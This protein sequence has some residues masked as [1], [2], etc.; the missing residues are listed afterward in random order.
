MTSAVD[1]LFRNPTTGRLVI[2][3]PPNA[4]LW[5]FL[6]ASV[7]RRLADP[8]GLPGTLLDGAAAVGLV[9]WAGDEMARGDSRFRRLLGAVVL[10]AFVL[11]LIRR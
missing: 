4:P 6:A 7:T 3:Q 8:S 2:A 9:W 10:A 5:L 11:G 1:W